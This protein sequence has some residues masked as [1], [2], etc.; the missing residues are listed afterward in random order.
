MDG[1]ERMSI[2]DDRKIA[3]WRKQ[4]EGYEKDI[5]ELNEALDVQNTTVV[6][7]GE[8]LEAA[9]KNAEQWQMMH[10]EVYAENQSFKEVQVSIQK[11]VK[12]IEAAHN[13]AI[14]AVLRI[15]TD[16]LYVQWELGNIT[17]TVEIQDKIAKMRR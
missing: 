1:G 15:I 13:A 16:E 5:A 6:E 14:D 3:E 2:D 7:L 4:F 11:Y 10:D 8:K 9:E 17:T 12:D